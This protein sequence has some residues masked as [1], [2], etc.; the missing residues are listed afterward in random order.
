M[1]NLIYTNGEFYDNLIIALKNSIE[2][3]LRVV[4]DY[5]KIDLFIVEANLSEAEKDVK[6]LE[7]IY[8]ARKK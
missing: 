8:S 7:E 2:Y 5:K 1:E 3:H 6:K 4:R